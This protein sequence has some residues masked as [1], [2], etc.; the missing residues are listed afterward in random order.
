MLHGL[1]LL[2]VPFALR[3]AGPDF[4]SG[5]GLG[6]LQERWDYLWTP[7]TEGCLVEASVHGTTVP[8][9]VATRFAA[10][11][12]AQREAGARRSASAATGLLAQACVLG[13]H[14][15]VGAGPRAGA[16][17]PGRRRRVRRG[18]HGDRPARPAVGVAR[19]AGGPPARR[20]AAA[21]AHRLRASD[22][23]RP[24]AHRTGVRAGRSGGRAGPAA[25]AAG[26][27]GRVGT[28][29]RALL[30]DGASG[31]RPPTTSPSCAARPP[32]WPTPSGRIDDAGLAR[33]V[34]GHLSGTSTAA[35]AVG[36]LRGLLLT[37]R[38]A[39][40]QDAR[41]ARQ[42]RRP[43]GGVGRGD[44]HRAPARA[45]TGVRRHDAAG[46]R[47][48]RPAVA[49]LHGAE[50]LG[51]LLLRDVDEERWRATCAVVTRQP[52]PCWPATACRTLGGERMS[53]VERWRL[54]LGRYCRSGTS[55]RPRGGQ[56]RGPDGGGP[57]LPLRPRVRGTRTCGPT[58]SGRAG[59]EDSHPHLVTWLGEVRELFPR[60]TAEVIEKHA[61]DRYGLTELV[62][63]P[64][65]SSVSSRASSC[66]RPC[67]PSR[68]TSTTRCS[69][70]PGGSS[71][72]WSRS[73]AARLEMD[74]R[75][76]WP[77][78]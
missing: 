12:D 19:A 11:L 64:R 14:D 46:D 37:A 56:R 66:S 26:Q 13:L 61:L 41:P 72:R 71:G 6:R 59:S 25:R 31:S 30:A 65:R 20:P 7:A 68:G 76:R 34:A 43:P 1:A 69:W 3:V 17:G 50:E 63:D 35:E 58:T 38:E 2:G 40:W 70:S 8:L 16:R 9:A 33:A 27:R 23:P 4:V 42:H 52:Q 48:H 29:R 60:E 39:A 44:V 24:R 5:H 75:R 57:R 32:G 10:R 21:A 67:S 49:G 77:A 51:R 45:A 28:R 62:T 22:V 18:R 73:C 53:G 47:P 55:V 54:V 15:H 74:V 36:F 78:G